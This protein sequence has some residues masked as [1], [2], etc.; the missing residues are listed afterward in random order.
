MGIFV[1]CCVIP[2]R[3]RLVLSWL[4]VFAIVVELGMLGDVGLRNLGVGRGVIGFWIAVWMIIGVMRFVM[5]GFVRLVERGVCMGVNV[6]GW[7][8][9]GSVVDG[10]FGVWGS[11]GRVWSV[12]SMFVRG[13]VIRVSVGSVRFKGGG[14]VLVGRGFIKG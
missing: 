5:T 2:A 1:F 14:S 13:G 11:V 7:R 6:G 8:R 3:V 10:F 4:N 12:G 9:R